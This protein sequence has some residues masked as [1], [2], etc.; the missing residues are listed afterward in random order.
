MGYVHPKRLHRTHPLKLY[1]YSQQEEGSR[2]ANTGPP[3]NVLMLRGHVD[4]DA[5]S[6]SDPLQRE[7]LVIQTDNTVDTEIRTGQKSWRDARPNS[8][9]R[10]E[11]VTGA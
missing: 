2:P 1:A 5:F 10:C 9:E 8:R 7:L 11:F 6:S 4:G 3:T